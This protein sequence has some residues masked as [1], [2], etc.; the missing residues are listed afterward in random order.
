MSQASPVPAGTEAHSILKQFGFTP[1]KVGMWLFL[2]SDAMGFLGLI[3]S[4]IIL[5]ASLIGDWIPEGAWGR[6]APE[7]LPQ[8]DPIITGFNTFILICSSYTMVRAVNAITHD[9][10]KGLKFWLGL[11]ILLGVTFL[12][13]Q[14]YEYQHL[15]HMGLHM[16]AH[17][18]GATF[19]L[20]TG[21]HGAHVFSGVIYMSCI[22]LRAAKGTYSSTNYSPVELVG[23]FW[24]FVDLV[25][26][27]LFTI[28]YLI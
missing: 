19:F 12:G 25:W 8:L 20:C 11:T 17:P 6:H 26:I 14:V 28:L 16:N 15:M 9:D 5:R 27:I 2:A 24:H 7:G 4:Y 18:Y 3:G 21:F 23:L 22:W 1:G 10:Q 13:I